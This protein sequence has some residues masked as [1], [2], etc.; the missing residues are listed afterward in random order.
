MLPASEQRGVVNKTL[1]LAGFE[2]KYNQY[3]L[4]YNFLVK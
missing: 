1:N 4:I 3:F 2:I